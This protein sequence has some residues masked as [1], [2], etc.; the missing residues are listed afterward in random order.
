MVMITLYCYYLPIIKTAVFHIEFY[1]YLFIHLQ[2][3]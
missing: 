1:I 2:K 3:Q